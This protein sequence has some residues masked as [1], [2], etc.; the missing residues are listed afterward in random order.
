MTAPPLLALLPAAVLLYIIYSDL[1]DLRIPNWSVGLLAALFMVTQAPFLWGEPLIWRLAIALAVFIVCFVLFGFNLLGGG[2]VKLLPVVLLFVPVER[3]AWYLLA[4]SVCVIATLTL[5]RI[6][7]SVRASEGGN[8]RGLSDH[9]RYPLGP[10]IAISA[11][12]YN[13]IGPLAER[14]VSG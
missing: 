6:A 3:L 1:H 9:A 2:D 12:I 5:I 14:L 10:A 11:L 13:Q 4:L 8:W 7:R